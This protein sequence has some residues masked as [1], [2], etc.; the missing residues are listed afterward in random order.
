[1]NQRLLEHLVTL[2]W[3]LPTSSPMSSDTW[4]PKGSDL[5]TGLHAVDWRLLR[6]VTHPARD[7]YTSVTNTIQEVLT[8][9]HRTSKL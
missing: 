3:W 7:R 1:V 6:L 8:E 4:P 9:A 2:A 5:L